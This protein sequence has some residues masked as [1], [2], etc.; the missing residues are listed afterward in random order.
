MKY[1]RNLV[2]IALVKSVEIGLDHAFDDFEIV[3]AG[4]GVSSLSVVRNVIEYEPNSVE[5]TGR[6]QSATAKS[7]EMSS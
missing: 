5:G 2:S 6:K 1:A 3:S 7:R 4:H